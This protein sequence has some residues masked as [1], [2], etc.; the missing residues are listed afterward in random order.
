[1]RRTLLAAT[2]IAALLAAGCFEFLTGSNT[3]PSSSGVNGLSGAWASVSSATT[4]QDTCTNFTW[5]VTDISG[6]TASGA[7]TA[8][9][10]GNLN[11]TGTASGTLSGSTVNWTATGTAT[12]P[13]GT[14][15]PIS[16]SGTAT[17]DGTQIR[18]PYSGTTCLGSVS[19]T[20][21]LR[22]PG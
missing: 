14:E 1:M 7:F 2:V 10:L 6:N 3:S 5:S 9:C 8:T 18:I 12:A 13:D 20:E 11:V 21:I 16:L 4:L 15:C 17:F 22:R 19:G